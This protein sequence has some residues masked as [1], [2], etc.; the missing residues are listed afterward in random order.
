MIWTDAQQCYT[1][2]MEVDY[3]PINA[4]PKVFSSSGL[5]TEFFILK[6]NLENQQNSTEST[7]S[8]QPESRIHQH[9]GKH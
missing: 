2:H 1:P 7:T 6:H 5:T 8:D 9:C 3:F 4:H